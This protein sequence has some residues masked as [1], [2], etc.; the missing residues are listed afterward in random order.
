MRRRTLLSSVASIG[1]LSV[2]GCIDDAGPGNGDPATDDPTTTPGEGTDD[3]TDTD[4]GD[5]DTEFGPDEREEVERFAIGDREAVAFPDNNNPVPVHVWNDA[6]SEREFGLTAST[7]ARGRDLGTVAVA[8]DAYV[9]VL[10]NVPAEYTLTVTGDGRTLHE[11]ALDHTDFDCNSGFHSVSVHEDWSVD[12]GGIST[13][14]ACSGPENRSGGIG[15][16]EGECTDRDASEATV[17][18]YDDSVG[19]EGVFVTPNPCYE[20]DLADTSY[21][22]ETDTF[23]AVVEAT[24]ATGTDEACQECLGQVDYTL[25]FGFANDLPGHVVLVHRRDGE[26]TEVARATWNADVNLGDGDEVG[27]FL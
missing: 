9:T 1:A 20:L 27:T 11:H 3:G 14:I 26:E 19:A 17:D 10:F 15:V 12:T 22:E 23:R 8:G 25:D 6:E 5:D 21:D 16:S 24:D 13:M 7:G 2:A 4:D 18:Y